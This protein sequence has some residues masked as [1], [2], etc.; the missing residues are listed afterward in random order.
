LNHVSFLSYQQFRLTIFSVGTI[1]LLE[2]SSQP[3]DSIT[4]TA[5]FL[6]PTEHEENKKNE[7]KDHM[8][9]KGCDAHG[10]QHRGRRLNVHLT[11]LNWID[12]L[13]AAMPT[14]S[15]HLQATK[16]MVASSPTRMQGDVS[17]NHNTS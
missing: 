9:S 17:T 6:A 1:Q 16:G 10:L 14:K 8:L 11:A 7:S 4:R 13:R 2:L 3:G 12:E 5:L 15:S